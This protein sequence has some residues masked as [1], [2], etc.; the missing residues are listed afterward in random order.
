MLSDGLI[1]RLA[2]QIE[3]PL[4]SVIVVGIVVHIATQV[5]IVTN[6]LSSYFVIWFAYGYFAQV[7]L[8]NYAAVAQH[9][10]PELSGRANA[11][12]WLDS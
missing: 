10:E 7:A 5:A 1:S 11:W 3:W 2:K 8:V 6:V 9:F 4:T 12:H